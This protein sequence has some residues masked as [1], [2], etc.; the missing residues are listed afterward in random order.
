MF[1]IWMELLTETPGSV[2]WMRTGQRAVLENLAREAKSR[3]VSAERLIFAPRMAALREHLARYRAADLFLDSL[4]YGAHT[5]ARDALWSGLPV[6]TCMGNTFAGRVAGS[7]LTA[8]DLPELVTSSLEEYA[9]RA[10]ALAHSPAL[11]AAL[12]AKLALHRIT[13]PAFDTDLYRRHLESAYAAMCE[14]QRRGGEPQNFSV[15]ALR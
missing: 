12:R 6:L 4:P 3:G 2:L 5:T 13:K 8:L 9:G 1:D 15:T 10:L 7:L 11:C 14:R